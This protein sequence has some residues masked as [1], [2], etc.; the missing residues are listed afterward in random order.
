VVFVATFKN[1]KNPSIYPR[2]LLTHYLFGIQLEQLYYYGI[3]G[4]NNAVRS[5]MLND[6]GGVPKDL[7]TSHDYDPKVFM[8]IRKILFEN[9]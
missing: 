9:N 7:L 5:K 3:H 1:E 4:W 8:F 2:V 6:L